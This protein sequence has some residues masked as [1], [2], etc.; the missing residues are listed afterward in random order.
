M[1]PYLSTELKDLM[2]NLL[3]PLPMKRFTVQDIW[4]HPWIAGGEHGARSGEFRTPDYV[5]YFRQER[6]RFEVLNEELIT[7]LY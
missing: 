2:N 5:A 7:Q 4:R 6:S 3:Q 1:P